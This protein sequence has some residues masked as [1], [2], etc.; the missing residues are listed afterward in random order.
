MDFS[1][2]INFEAGRIV[3]MGLAAPK[4]HR[5]EAALDALQP[6]IDEQEA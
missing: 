3:S 5:A 6:E 1:E 2:W 4:E